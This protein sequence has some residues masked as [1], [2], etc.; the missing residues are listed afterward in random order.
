MFSLL[1]VVNKLFS[2]KVWKGHNTGRKGH[3]YNEI[4]F[5]QMKAKSNTSS[6]KIT[7]YADES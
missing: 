6:R 4:S 1:L 3:R 7:T 2:T 5:Y